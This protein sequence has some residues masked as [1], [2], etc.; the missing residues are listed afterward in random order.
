MRLLLLRHGQTPANVIGS[1]DTAAPG[2]RL[3]PL[4]AAQAAAVP[5]ALSGQRVDAIWV[6]TLIRTQ[7][8]AAPFADDRS[9][10]PNV[11]DGFREIEAGDLEDRT[12]HESQLRYLDT[13][14]AWADGRRDIH[15][16]G[17]PDGNAFF[18]RY[19]A[20]IADVAAAT[21]PDG[22]ALVVSHGMAIRTWVAGTALNVTADFAAKNQL[23]NTGM[24]VLESSPAAHAG[25]LEWSMLE[26][27]GVPI[28][29][30]ALD[31]VEAE[32]PTGETM[33]DARRRLQE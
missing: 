33:T 32:D 19:D 6:S 9:L 31:D 12:D 26:W 14:F 20:A 17:A 4:G 25:A 30:V 1:L 11:V 15:L 8:T 13:A 29:G 18:A 16:P 3:T 27:I 23:G 21:P 24:A 10:R 28:G 2:P 7:L 5:G 22:V